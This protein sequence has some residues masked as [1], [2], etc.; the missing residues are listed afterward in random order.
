LEVKHQPEII[1]INAD[2]LLRMDRERVF[3]HINVEKQNKTTKLILTI[4]NEWPHFWKKYQNSKVI[5][6]KLVY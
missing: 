1:Y 3:N 2:D 6:P 4:D 5:A